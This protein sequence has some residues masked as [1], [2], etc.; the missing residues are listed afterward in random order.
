M[1]FPNTQHKYLRFYFNLW[2]PGKR[3]CRCCAEI[4]R[5]WR[6]LWRTLDL[7]QYSPSSFNSLCFLNHLLWNFHFSLLLRPVVLGCSFFD[8]CSLPEF[9]VEVLEVRALASPIH[10]PC[11]FTGTPSRYLG[12]CPGFRF[13][14]FIFFLN[15]L[16]L[17]LS[18]FPI[19]AGSKRGGFRPA[20]TAKLRCNITSS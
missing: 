16:F 5:P 13:S 10:S 19:S 2:R 7:S 9:E 15:Q 20:S 1:Y 8:S 11:P 18:P 3:C 14:S 4:M 12:V 17:R 6:L